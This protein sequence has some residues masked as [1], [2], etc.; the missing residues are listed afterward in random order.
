MKGDTQAL[1]SFQV[2]RKC[3]KYLSE[4]QYTTT[5]S[6]VMSKSGSIGNNL[7]LLRRLTTSQKDPK[8]RTL[9]LQQ[10]TPCVTAISKSTAFL[11]KYQLFSVVQQA[12]VNQFTSKMSF[13]PDF[14]RQ[15]LI[16]LRLDSQP[17]LTATRCKTSLILN[18]NKEERVFSLLLTQNELSSLLMI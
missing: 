17:R 2:E 7:L 8:F 18:L 4:A 9:L 12:Q 16:Q 6:L 5:S 11:T 13:C 3:L 15:S 1:K 14:L 10:L